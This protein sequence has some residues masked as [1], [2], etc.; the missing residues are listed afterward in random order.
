MRRTSKSLRLYPQ[1]SAGV[2]K[3]PLVER[4]HVMMLA[5]FAQGPVPIVTSYARHVYPPVFPSDL[6]SVTIESSAVQRI[7]AF[8]SIGPT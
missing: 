2:L 3:M 7:H 4:G 6:P 1:Q 5:G 8:G